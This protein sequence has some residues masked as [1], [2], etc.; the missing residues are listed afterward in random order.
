MQG[1]SYADACVYVNELYKCI[2]VSILVIFFR[3][4]TAWLVWFGLC[5]ATIT[6]IETMNYGISKTNEIRKELSNENS[7]SSNNKRNSNSFATYQIL[8]PTFI[9]CKIK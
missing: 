1:Y 5:L 2:F 8:V 6:N 9:S 7:S 3:W 4:L